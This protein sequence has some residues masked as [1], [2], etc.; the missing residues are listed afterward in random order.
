MMASS[1]SSMGKRTNPGINGMS[2]TEAAMCEEMPKTEISFPYW[3]DVRIV[4]QSIFR[5]DMHGAA[6]AARF[7]SQ[8][9]LLPVRTVFIPS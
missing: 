2:D 1:S 8:M 5:S 4:R 3:M 6:P 7:T 9:R